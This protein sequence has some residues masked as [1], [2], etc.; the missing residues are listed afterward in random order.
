MI[1]VSFLASIG[2]LAPICASATPAQDPADDRKALIKVSASLVALTKVRVVDGTGAPPRADQTIVIENGKIAAVGPTGRV[3]VPRGATT[4]ALAGHTVIPGLVGLHNH[5][6]YTTAAGR[7]IQ[8]SFSFPRLYLAGG[9]TTIRTTGSIEPYVEIAIKQQIERG[10][11]VGPRMYIS[12][13]YISG[14]GAEASMKA[15]KT[16]EDARRVVRYWAEE[17][18][19]WFKVYTLIS[20]RELAAA[21]EEA[22]QHGLKITGHLCS[23]GYRE[24][25][26]LG[27]DA[28]EHGLMG[29]LEFHPEKK[30][31]QCPPRTAN[32]YNRLDLGSRAVQ[33][34]FRALVANQ[35]A[36]T[37]TLATYEEN[38]PNRPPLD[39]RV[40]DAL[41]PDARSE[42]LTARKAYAA[43]PDNA[44]W[45]K[46][47]RK[48]MDFEVAF[49]RAGGLLGAGVDPTGMGIALA[50]FGDQ[51]NFELLV[52][53][54]FT[55]V[56]AI[57]I[58][59]LNGARILGA[60]D[61]FGSIAPGM[62]ADLVV[63][64]GDPTARPTDI[65]NVSLVFKE[66]VG[67]DSAKLIESVKGQVGIR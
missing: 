42:V 4:L 39:Q 1:R 56:E 51:R 31:D 35:V 5:T 49:V 10:E 17:G 44:A 65:R 52:E 34:T 64:Q 37:S 8:Q 53:A 7:S 36:M 9:V 41:S 11:L 15:V 25:A 3:P 45:A 24:A 46:A 62:S 27:M 47:Y 32:H 33:E 48:V 54:G 26:A 18:V 21:I 6:F 30:P 58:M 12:G 50:G 19:D 28:V 40:L 16:P 59:S 2:L 29:D 60:A 14:P 38:V 67:Y 13:P 23:V 55:A 43:N 20:R 22:H 61:R 57:K 63:I 66:G